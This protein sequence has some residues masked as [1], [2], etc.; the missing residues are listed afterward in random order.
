[1]KIEN[2]TIGY[3]SNKSITTIQ[4]GINAKL[5][6][7][8]F[9]CLLG[10][11]GSGKSTLLRT[12]AGFQMP[13]NGTIEINGK[14]IVDCSQKDLSTLIS[15]VLTDRPSLQSM[16]VEQLISLGRSPYTGLW[17]RITNSDKKMIN[18][19]VSLT[20]TVELKDRLVDTLSDGEL[21]KVMIAKAIAQNTEII[22]LDEPTAFLDFPGKAEAF[23]LL[24][25]MAHQQK[26]IILQSTH[27]INMAIAVADRLW[28]IDKEY[29]FFTGTPREL[30][31]EGILQ[32]FFCKNQVTF[33]QNSLTFS[34][35]LNS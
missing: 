11:N 29:G 24:A 12:L 22:L 30:A 18:E 17:G 27:D 1:M 19:A 8:E 33:N 21:Q 15:I 13:L 2:L 16:T 23:T 32:K 10:P 3:N 25:D 9:V 35:S 6:P 4:S 14:N 26:K 20:S 28:L 7:G 31:D 34:L 5:Q